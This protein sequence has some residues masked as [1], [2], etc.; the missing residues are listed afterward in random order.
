MQ[1]AVATTPDVSDAFAWPIFGLANDARVALAEARERREMAVLATLYD[2]AGGAPRGL[3]AQ[4]VFAGGRISGYLSGGCI[5]AD[6][7]SHAEAVRAGGAP[8][9]LTYGDGGPM[10][11]RLPCGSRIEVLLERIDPNDD[12]VGALLAMTAARRP[13]M[14]V[15]DGTS[16]TC[17]MQ[18]PLP[19]ASPVSGLLD[20]GR[21]FRAF[22]PPTRLIVIGGDPVALAVCRLA[23][24]MGLETTL[25]R[26]RGPAAAPPVAGLAYR[27]EDVDASLTAL[28]PDRWTAIC[29]LTHE[30]E[31]DGGLLAALTTRAGYVGAIGSRRRVAPR[32]AALLAAGASPEAVEALRMP[33]GLVAGASS[34]WQIAVSILDE[35]TAAIG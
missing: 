24:D 2:A 15:T 11:I 35:I 34:P 6:V 12:A 17:A 14:W 13:A 28:A 21:I 16:R 31:D 29:I 22:A 27:A 9:R 32:K 26:P 8:R 23:L 3:G 30:A 10:D 7:A 19:L 18:P 4:M 1:N 5:E 20:D 25:V 33:I